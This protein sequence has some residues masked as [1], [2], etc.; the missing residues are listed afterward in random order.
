[1][2]ELLKALHDEAARTNAA[3]ALEKIKT[4]PDRCV[5]ALIEALKSG[6]GFT[7]DNAAAALGEFG[8]AAKAAVPLLI[9]GLKSSDSSL[10]SASAKSLGQIGPDAAEAVPELAKFVA[11]KDVDW[12]HMPMVFALG[13]IGKAGLPPLIPLLKCEDSIVRNCAF[14][15]ITQMGSDAAGAVPTLIELLKQND[16]DRAMSAAQTLG[17]IGP[18]AQAAIAALLESARSGSRYTA[19]SAAHA[20]YEIDPTAAA[21]AQIDPPITAYSFFIQQDADVFREKQRSL[22]KSS[23]IDG[24]V[25]IWI[26]GDPFDFFV[27]GGAMNQLNAWLTPGQ[28]ELTLSQPHQAPMYVLVAPRIVADWADVIGQRAFQ[29]PGATKLDA[30]LVFQADRAPRLPKRDALENFPQD[31]LQKEVEQHVERIVGLIRA[32]KGRE[33]AELLFAGKHL[34][35]KIADGERDKDLQEEVDEAVVNLSDPQTTV[36]VSER[37]IK[38]LVGKHSLMAFI[39]MPHGAEDGPPIISLK[40]GTREV[41]LHVLHF[42]HV[43][44]TLIVWDVP[45]SVSVQL[46]A[47]EK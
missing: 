45:S 15:A 26:N 19:E 16:D 47:K 20:L 42:A 18:A 14:V 37:P 23:K 35:A 36:S 13:G 5:P 39:D 28:N 4:D 12:T 30:P 22:G 33:A 44:G 40:N 17:K 9:E 43:N 46:S 2:P 41:G 7:K 25:V 31:L 6:D 8:V 10:Q 24:P 29:N 21:R 38:M 27:G 34:W 1:V 11:G 32:H 3:A